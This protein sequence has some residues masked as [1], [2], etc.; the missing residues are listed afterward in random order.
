MILVNK[1][2]VV[3]EHWIAP[4][5]QQLQDQNNVLAL[6]IHWSCEG[7]PLAHD[8]EK[9]A[10][11]VHIST[12]RL[13][14]ILQE[15][16]LPQFLRHGRFT[17][18]L[19]VLRLLRLVG[20]T[21]LTSLCLFE[22]R[23]A[24]KVVLLHES[25]EAFPKLRERH[26][27]WVFSL[28]VRQL[29]APDELT[30][31]LPGSVEFLDHSRGLR[32]GHVLVVLCENS[33]GRFEL[34]LFSKEIP[35]A[36][37][38]LGE[39]SDLL[40]RPGAMVVDAARVIPKKVLCQPDQGIELLLA[41]AHGGALGDLVHMLAKGVQ[42]LQQK[43]HHALLHQVDIEVAI[44]LRHRKQHLREEAIIDLQVSKHLLLAAR[45]SMR[46]QDGALR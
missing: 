12:D 44:R 43:R 8:L 46:H 16:P 31:K 42:P 34:L 39:L 1:I 10:V 23:H 5:P 40:V 36:L 6:E 7:C 13:E 19:L 32:H 26:L 9:L 20:G 28:D 21:S 24:K 22:H 14:T 33:P 15:A 4:G 3:V 18:L 45:H 17:L 35:A 25:L 29:C 30:L 11:D 41:T 27:L 38:H 2:A 37:L